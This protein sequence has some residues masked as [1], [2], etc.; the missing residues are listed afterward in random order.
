MLSKT[1]LVIHVV[2]MGLLLQVGVIKQPRYTIG[3]G[4]GTS[5]GGTYTLSGTIG[6][7]S[8]SNQVLAGGAYTL[9][10]GFWALPTAPD[11]TYDVNGDGFITPADAVFVVNRIG[12]APTGEN[13]PADIDRDG[14]IDEDDANAVL[15]LVGQEALQ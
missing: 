13:A 4:G 8:A 6:E 11:Y 10:G 2:L 7:I 12:Q 15:A 3:S 1:T 5:T 9:R 14:D